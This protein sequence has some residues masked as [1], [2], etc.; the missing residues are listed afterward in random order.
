MGRR[1]SGEMHIDRVRSR[2]TVVSGETRQ[3]ES[4]LLRRSYRKP[5]GTMGKQTLANDLQDRWTLSKLYGIFAFPVAFLID[6]E[7]MI[8]HDVTQ[9]P[10]IA[11]LLTS[12]LAL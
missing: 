5:H 12:Q 2:H 1:P 11:T 3:Y 4:S 10:M 9:G 8:S 6:E 7:G